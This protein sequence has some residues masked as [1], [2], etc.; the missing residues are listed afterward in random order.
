MSKKRDIASHEECSLYDG[1]KAAKPDY[2]FYSATCNSTPRGT[3]SPFARAIEEKSKQQ[4]I[5]PARNI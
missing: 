1:W 2:T 3:P 4:S 5:A